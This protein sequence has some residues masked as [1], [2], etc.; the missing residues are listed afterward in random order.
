MTPRHPKKKNDDDDDNDDGDDNDGDDNDDDNVVHDAHHMHH[1]HHGQMQNS[2]IEKTTV[3]EV[4]A[5]DVRDKIK[6]CTKRVAVLLCAR[7]WHGRAEG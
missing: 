5:R 3:R 4:T 2:Y 6:I 7:V 1:G